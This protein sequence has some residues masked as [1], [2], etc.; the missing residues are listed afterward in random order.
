MVYQCGDIILEALKS[1]DGFVDEIHC[2]D[3]CWMPKY[4]YI[5]YSNDDTQS[6][7]E[8]F[9]KTSKSKIEYHKITS[10]TTEGRARIESI[11]N[12]AEK[13]WVFVLDADEVVTRWDSNIRSILEQTNEPCYFIHW[14]NS[15]IF[16]ICRFFRKEKG[17]GY[18]NNNPCFFDGK[19]VGDTKVNLICI[20]VNHNTRKRRCTHASEFA[21]GPHP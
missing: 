14:G 3:S 15:S 1:I 20:N 5:P 7:I 8:E 16:P 10:P 4:S 12:I 13:D 11:A 2:Y 9:S 21:Q 17:M 6:V 18:H 19:N